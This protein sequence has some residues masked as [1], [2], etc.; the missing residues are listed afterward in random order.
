MG[1]TS[2]AKFRIFTTVLIGLGLVGFYTASTAIRRLSRIV[3]LMTS[4][5]LKARK[6]A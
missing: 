2:D 3:E 5:P 6:E 4:S 1:D